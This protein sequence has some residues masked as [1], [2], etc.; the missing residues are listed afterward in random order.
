MIFDLGDLSAST[1]AVFN[2]PTLNE[3]LS[4]L[5][6]DTWYEL[7]VWYDKSDASSSDVGAIDVSIQSYD[8]GDGSTYNWIEFDETVEWCGAVHQDNRINL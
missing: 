5:N 4:D 3:A 1:D 6:D 7:I 2:L 8:A